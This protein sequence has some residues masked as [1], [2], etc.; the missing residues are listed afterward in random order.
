VSYWAGDRTH[1]PTILASTSTAACSRSTP[2]PGARAVVRQGGA[3][4]LRA[5]VADRFPN[6]PVTVPSPGIV[7]KN[8]IVTGSRGQEDNPEGPAPDVRAWDLRTGT[9]VWTFH[10]IPHPGEAGAD[11]WPADY[12]KTAARQATGG[13]GRSMSS[14]G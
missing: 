7:Y 2:P 11:T 6:M 3:I 10:T 14:A 8:L 4:N 1:R 13:R 12:W 9:L 5:G